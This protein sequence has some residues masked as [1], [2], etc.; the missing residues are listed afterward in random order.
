VLAPMAASALR[1]NQLAVTFIT[2]PMTGKE[3][4][5]K[6][7]AVKQ[8]GLSKDIAHLKKP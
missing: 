8:V 1:K 7:C 2:I 4:R 5:A 6:L 3:C